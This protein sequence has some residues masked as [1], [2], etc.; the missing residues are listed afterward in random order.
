LDNGEF[1]EALHVAEN[2]VAKG[3]FDEAELL[4][5]NELR[6]KVAVAFFKQ[7]HYENFCE[8]AI[9]SELDPREVLAMFDVLLPFPSGFQPRMM[10]AC[11][12]DDDFST[13]FVEM[14]I[15]LENY[16][17]K[18][19]EL[20]WAKEFARDID[21]V[22]LRLMSEQKVFLNPEDMAMNFRCS[23]VDCC[24][25]MRANDRRKFLISIAF[26]FGDCE[27]ALVLSR[28]LSQSE[29]IL[30]DWIN[31]LLK[32]GQDGGVIDGL[33]ECPI[34]LNHSKVVESLRCDQSTL[35]RYLEEI[36]SLQVT[37]IVSRKPVQ[38]IRLCIC[39]T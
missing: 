4:K 17:R 25:W 9:L 10:S 7:K 34:K 26:C 14:R 24:E 16:L 37:L 31:F 27:T 19:R 30:L 39:I 28:E 20:R 22:L 35:I 32:V 8:L 5:L 38:Q 13:A 36:K 29:K 6:Q 21:A 23:F 3:Q 11:G 2:A 12:T 18:V 15:F 1:D 33:K